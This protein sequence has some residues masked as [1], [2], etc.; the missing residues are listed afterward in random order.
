MKAFKEKYG[1]KP[2]SVSKGM[3]AIYNTIGRGEWK[4]LGITCWNDILRLAFG[5]VFFEKNKYKGKSGLENAI[6]YLKEYKKRYG[7]I[8]SLRSKGMSGISSAI[9]RGEWREFGIN[10]W[11]DLLYSVFGEINYQSKGYVGKEGLNRAINTLK[12]FKKKY[13]KKPA[14]NDKGISGIYSA[15]RR[16][17]WKQY[18]ISSWNDLLK[19]VFEEVNN[20]K[21]KYVGKKGLERAV[22]ELREMKKASKEYPK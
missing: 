8:P 17:I 21:N 10:S 19:L 2:T 12:E 7:K 3:P 18:G 13:G 11:N 1:R 22:K 9:L 5:E 16:G 20:E 4:Y 15:I 14:A 6:E